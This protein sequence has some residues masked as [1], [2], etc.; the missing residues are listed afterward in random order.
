MHGQG[1][2][3]KRAQKNTKT[4]FQEGYGLWKS[5]K[6]GDLIREVKIRRKIVESKGRN[7]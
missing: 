2:G 6:R 1:E 4:F 5:E 3:K 7:S